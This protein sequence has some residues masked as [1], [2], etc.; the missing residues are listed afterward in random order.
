MRFRTKKTWLAAIA[1]VIV[2]I[3]TA[4]I[5]LHRG[6]NP[7]AVLV[8]PGGNSRETYFTLHNVKAAQA[9]STGGGVKVG[10]LDHSFATE[11]HPA[12]YAGARNFVEGSDEFLTT[13]EWH[14]Y[15][16]A[17]VL[18]E[19]APGA[20]IYALNTYSFAGQAQR[21]KAMSDAITW[22]IENK[23]D[24]LSYSAAAFDG[25][26]RTL[27]DAALQRA[28]D[29]G[30]VTA[31]LHVAEP[32]NILPSG[33]WN[34]TEDGREPDVN[35]LQ[36]DYSV[37]FIDD[38]RKA[39][40]GQKGRQPPFLSL[41]S[42]APVVAGVVALIKNLKPDLTPA[43]CQAILRETSRPL[44]YNGRKPTRVLDA[45]AAVERVKRMS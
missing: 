15:W 36:Y 38:Y 43:E 31:F 35:V 44:D 30:I 33:L 19:I 23:L 29:A 25:E 40:A 20:K 7:D 34:G 28:H 37:V 26:S 16:M 12:L 1:V 2:G 3:P 11:L 10:I 41:S 39:V 22:A 6:D 18:H 4:Y 27:L 8:F 14:G 5:A 42:T 9:Y 45:L 17:T 32:G 21:A 24:V 13:R